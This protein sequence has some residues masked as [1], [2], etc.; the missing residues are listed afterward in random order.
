VRAHEK[1][2]NVGL[3]GDDTPHR[4]LKR[5]KTSELNANTSGGSDAQF[6]CFT[7]DLDDD[8][9]PP[10]SV[11]RKGKQH[12]SSLARQE[13]MREIAAELDQIV[14]LTV[15]EVENKSRYR[16]EKLKFF[17]ESEQK[18]TALMDEELEAAQAR[19]F[20]KYLALFTRPHENLEGQV[21]EAVLARKRVIALR[22]GWHFMK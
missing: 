6:T 14:K 2:H 12:A 4:S 1:W 13:D 15:Q 17:A 16:A 11:N 19:K 22:N 5:S 20:E 9:N 7:Q 10:T 3:E 21:R 8:E 18:K